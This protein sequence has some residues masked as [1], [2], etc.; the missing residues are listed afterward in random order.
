MI[1]FHTLFDLSFLT[2]IPVDRHSLPLLLL[3]R[4]TAL[5]FI[6]IVGISLTISYSRSSDLPKKRLRIKYLKR[7]L[8]IFSYGL[9]ITLITY[10]FIPENYIIFGILHFIG[11]S[12]ILVYPLIDKELLPLLVALITIPLG[13][14]LN[15]LSTDTSYLIWLGISPEAFTT[16]DYF[17]IL[18]WIGVILIGIYI[19][20]RAYPRGERCFKV[21]DLSGRLPVKI[22]SLLGR[23]SLLIY[24]LHQPAIIGVLYFLRLLR[25]GF[26]PNI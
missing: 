10:L 7:G 26:L 13:S 1:V 20:H 24:F 18:P 23:R 6:F 16:V 8:K 5:T 21:P 14:W 17:P 4:F 25:P 15:T 12:I 9:L 11:L 2:S 19:G 3:A 22:F